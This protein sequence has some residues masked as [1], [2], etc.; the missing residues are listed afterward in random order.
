MTFLH[1]IRLALRALRRSPGFTAVTLLV[2]ALGIAINTTMFSVV[3]AVVLRPLPFPAPEQLIA[4]GEGRADHARPVR[5]ESVSW[6]DF[7]DWRV[8]SRTVAAMAAHQTDAYVLGGGDRPEMVRG[9]AVSAG[10]FDV[11]GVPPALG[12]GFLAG[13]D[14]VGRNHVA[15]LSDRLWRRRFGA[16]PAVVGRKI[17][18][19][20]ES[21][22]VVGV[23]PG[24]LHFPPDDPEDEMW[25]PL[26]HG[27][28]DDPTKRGDHWLK[29]T[30]RLAPGA[31]LAQAH[32]ELDA[33]HAGL[34][35]LYPSQV[36]RVMRTQ[37]LKES[38]VK[39]VRAALLLLLVAVGFVLLIGCANVANL[40][41]ARATVRRR[42]MAVR[43]ALGASRG[44]IL[45]HLLVESGLLG[46]AG[47]ALGLGLAVWGL[48]LALALLPPGFPRPRAIGID[49]RVL[50]FTGL[51]AIATGLAFGVVPA[52]GGP[53]VGDALR[54]S[55]RTTARGR[56]R[57]V[58]LVAEVALTFVL[59]LGAGL[60]LRSLA[61]IGRVD[62]GF[63]PEG[64]LTATI[65][66]PSPAYRDPGARR[67]FYRRLLPR[68]QALPGA[69]GAAVTCPLPFT[70]WSFHTS[71][72]FPD[73]PPPP[74]GQ[75]PTTAIDFVSPDY[76]RVM[77]I[78]PIAGRLFTAADEAD[79]APLVAIV[80]ESL[81]RQHWP[82]ESPVGKRLIVGRGNKP[83]EIVGVVA[84]VRTMLDR[85]P[86]IDLYTPFAE[87]AQPHL[88]IVLRGPAPSALVGSLRA[89]VEAVDP[90]QPLD[91]VKTMTERVS[92]SL[93]ERRLSVLLL[94]VFGALAVLLAMV[95]I[96]G[97][98][99]YAVTQR[100]RELGI[101]MALGAHRPRILSMVL[102]QTVG[103][104]ALGLAAGLIPAL[105]LARAM[106]SQLHGV[107]P[108][109]P[110]TC[111]GLG[112]ALLAAATLASLLPAL[113]ATRVDPMLALR[114][115]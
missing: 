114:Q 76:F 56:A 104:A 71:M 19:D 80:S 87:T 95:G 4:I 11:L 102:R 82:G 62:P 40:L 9:L 6:L 98:M 93:Q 83:R 108:T 75:G 51:L 110:A 97:V 103:L 8:Q 96:H 90:G 2:L 45:R 16:D 35:R 63:R 99:S 112:A 49:G 78:A 20:G 70:D 57:A 18:V 34:A 31:T 53:T 37:G 3:D 73:R 17:T 107:S 38:M 32:A 39:D 50:A 67:D 43:I 13:E 74:P 84:D 21:Y 92:D 86:G 1:D 94:T 69:D 115:E 22:T 15:V 24:G 55:G 101:R 41:L 106:G 47:G 25:T 5:E 113:R 23:A 79:G 59:L 61:R 85:P 100:T 111:L 64:L 46:L 77:G 52:I 88:V 58:L 44:R 54:E 72:V 29:V 10:F 109:D 105:L 89:A 27:A 26:P 66:L 60:S 42:E 68:L 7:Q 30:G 81:A 14:Q 28:L 36:G 65:N 33:I 91:D 48:D 12:R